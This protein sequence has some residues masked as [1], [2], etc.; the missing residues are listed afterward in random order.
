M[1]PLFALNPFDPVGPFIYAQHTRSFRS[2]HSQSTSPVSHFRYHQVATN[3][4]FS[5]GPAIKKFYLIR[6][7]R[8]TPKR[9]H[10]TRDKRSTQGVKDHSERA[11]HSLYFESLSDI[12]TAALCHLGNRRNDAALHERRQQ[13]ELPAGTFEIHRG[14]AN[15]DSIMN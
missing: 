1:F 10:L 14:V 8:P 6:L 2:A 9:P 13:V 3:S 12:T 11:A 15:P 5:Y 7:L 4:I